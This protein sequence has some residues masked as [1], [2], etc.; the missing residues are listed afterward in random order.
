MFWGASEKTLNLHSYPVQTK[1][2]SM[3]NVLMVSKVQPLSGTVKK[4]WQT[5]PAMNKLYD[6]TKSGTV[7]ID[8]RMEFYSCKPKSPK[9]T[10]TA[11]TYVLDTCRVNASTVLAVNVGC[12][13]RAQDLFPFGCKLEMALILARPLSESGVSVQQKIGMILGTPEKM[14]PPPANRARFPSISSEKKQQLQEIN[15]WT[16]T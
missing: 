11:L 7:I 12:S 6:Y 5:K 3:R 15:S 8:Q 4:G 16:W 1:S 2:S 9:W 10:I 14:N 13:P